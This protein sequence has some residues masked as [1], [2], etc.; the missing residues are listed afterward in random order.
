M[1]GG[2]SCDTI[3]IAI[4]IAIVERGRGR[5]GR[6]GIV[7]EVTLVDPHLELKKNYI[8]LFSTFFSP[9]AKPIPPSPFFSFFFFFLSAL[10]VTAPLVKQQL[11]WYGGCSWLLS[12]LSLVVGGDKLQAFTPLPNIFFFSLS[13][14]H[15]RGSGVLA[16]SP[17]I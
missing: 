8:R 14:L 2:Y 13:L 6:G 1:S 11:S 17:T 5:G 16:H 7:P 9:T 15:A 3:A 10:C 4:A 12:L